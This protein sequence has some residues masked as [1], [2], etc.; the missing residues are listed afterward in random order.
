[1]AEAFL[2]KQGGRYYPEEYTALPKDVSAGKTFF[3]AEVDTL[4][5]GSMPVA[6]IADVIIEINGTYNIPAGDHQKEQKITQKE[7]P[8]KAAFSA[9]PRGNGVTVEVAGNY[10]QGDVT[11]TAA[12]NFNPAYIKR[13]VV[14]GEGSQAITGIY[15]GFE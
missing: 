1:M 5:T 7:V 15:E 3:G 2:L 14:V 13:G 11:I 6:S 8:L 12:E 10:M 4:Q 9:S